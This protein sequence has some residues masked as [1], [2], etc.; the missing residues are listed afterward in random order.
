MRHAP[1]GL[2]QMFCST[3]SRSRP[4]TSTDENVN[5]TWRLRE[6]PKRP[7][8]WTWRSSCACTKRK[9]I[10]WS[11]ATGSWMK[12]PRKPSGV[13][14]SARARHV[15]SIISTSPI[16]PISYPSSVLCIVP[17]P[18]PYSSIA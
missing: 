11:S 2:L 14:K 5:V 4:P 1:S 18:S 3:N 8:A 10:G 9:G 17:V 16:S 12:T 6:P 7:P 13:V 15:A